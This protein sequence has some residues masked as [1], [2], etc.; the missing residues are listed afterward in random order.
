[1]Q[2]SKNLRLRLHLFFFFLFKVAFSNV[3]FVF[4]LLLLFD[5]IHIFSCDF[6]LILIDSCLGICIRINSTY[7]FKTSIV[8]K[9]NNTYRNVMPLLAPA[10]KE[11]W[12]FRLFFPFSFV[13]LWKNTNPLSITFFSYNMDLKNC[14]YTSSGLSQY[15]F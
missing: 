14:K 5:H 1:M 2:N 6:G 3:L 11:N 9:F 7:T 8:S 4:I 13:N 10:L 12:V 15:Q